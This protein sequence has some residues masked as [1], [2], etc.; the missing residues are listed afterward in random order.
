MT[1][2]CFSRIKT[3]KASLGISWNFPILTAPRTFILISWKPCTGWYSKQLGSLRRGNRDR[4]RWLTIMYNSIYTYVYIYILYVYIYIFIYIYICVCM[5]VYFLYIYI[6]TCRRTRTTR[7]YCDISIVRC[8][9]LE[10]ERTISRLLRKNIQGWVP[11][12][13]L[14]QE[15]LFSMCC[16]DINSH[17]PSLTLSTLPCHGQLTRHPSWQDDRGFNFN[18]SSW[19]TCF[20]FL[21]RPFSYQFPHRALPKCQKLMVKTY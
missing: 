1:F 10:K 18:S 2:L 17:I 8:S 19:E 15:P 14:I 16:Y 11:G 5:Y 7:M 3:S 13:G 4:Q 21:P 12:F 9:A 6:H 20:I